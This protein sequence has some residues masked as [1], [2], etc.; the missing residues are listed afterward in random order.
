MTC[1]P[2]YT[3]NRQGRRYRLPRRS[4]TLVQYLEASKGNGR[5]QIPPID[6]TM[7]G[8]FG[9][10]LRLDGHPLGIWDMLKGRFTPSSGPFRACAVL[11]QIDG[12]RLEEIVEDIRERLRKLAS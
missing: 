7:A 5:Q 4:V 2:G 6:T 10:E 3:H 8:R 12:W 1:P 11:P 9:I